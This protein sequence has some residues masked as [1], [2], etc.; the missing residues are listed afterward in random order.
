MPVIVTPPSEQ[1]R[2]VIPQNEV[3]LPN[4]S[5]TLEKS[6]LVGMPVTSPDPYVMP[7][8]TSAVPV[9]TRPKRGTRPPKKDVPELGQWM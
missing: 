1:D 9:T 2:V 8:N 7:D 4:P 3:L 5:T 6:L